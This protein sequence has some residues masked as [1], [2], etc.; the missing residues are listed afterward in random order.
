ML[1]S[2]FV[3]LGISTID[4]LDKGASLWT[5]VIIFGSPT[6]VA[7]WS[8]PDHIFGKNTAVRDAVSVKSEYKYKNDF[9]TWREKQEFERQN[10][11]KS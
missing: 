9:E 3:D 8:A 4:A 7:H 2:K 6:D 1:A 10:N 5:P 11:A